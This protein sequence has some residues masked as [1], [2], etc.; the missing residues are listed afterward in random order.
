M[1]LVNFF[2][3]CV[4]YVAWLI[5]KK[6]R[7]RRQFRS[8]DPWIYHVMDS[9]QSEVFRELFRTR[10]EEYIRKCVKKWFWGAKT[11]FYRKWPFLGLKMTNERGAQGKNHQNATFFGFVWNGFFLL[12]LDKVSPWNGSNVG[13]CLRAA[14]DAYNNQLQGLTSI[15]SWQQMCPFFGVGCLH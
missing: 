5:R 8:R 3:I 2:L 15:P 7:R 10:I 11:R 14:I 12:N 1:D 4:D 6:G 9:D 13:I